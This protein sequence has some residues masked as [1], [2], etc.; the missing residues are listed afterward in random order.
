MTRS[1]ALAYYMAAWIIGAIFMSLGVWMRDPSGASITRLGTRSGPS[2][3][4]SVSDAVIPA[5]WTP[6]RA[7]QRPSWLRSC[8]RRRPVR[9]SRSSTCSISSV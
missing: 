4:E 3:Q 9:V 1:G 6:P 2:V 5:L 7:A 8:R